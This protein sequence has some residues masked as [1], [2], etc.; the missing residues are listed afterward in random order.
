MH[1]CMAGDDL[2]SST[3]IHL[4]SGFGQKPSSPPPPR[5][6]Q[7]DLT[8]ALRC[9]PYTRNPRV[10]SDSKRSPDLPGSHAPPG[11]TTPPA[12]PSSVSLFVSLTPSPS[13]SSFLRR[14]FHTYSS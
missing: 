4:C 12:R 6:L 11:I 8:C 13:S 14:S 3:S 2:S 9:H 5:H 1:L 10:L 7:F